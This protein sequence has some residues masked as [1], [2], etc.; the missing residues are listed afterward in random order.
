MIPKI[1]SV[2]DDEGFAIDPRQFTRGE[3]VLLSLPC[4]GRSIRGGAGGQKMTA[5]RFCGEVMASTAGP[6]SKDGR[7]YKPVL[8]YDSDGSVGVSWVD[9]NPI[10]HLINE[11]GAPHEA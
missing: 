11:Q 10:L 8:A 3:L 7:W 1:I 2:E 9:Y 6:H 4:P 5:C